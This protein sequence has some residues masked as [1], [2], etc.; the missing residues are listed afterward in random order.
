[1]GFYLN[2]DGS[3]F[4]EA[5]L[6][7]IYVD[8]TELIAVTNSVLRTK[9]KY[10]CVSRP[11]RFG[12]TMTLEMLEAYY[13]KGIN[14]AELFKHTKIYKNHDFAKYANKYNVLHLNMAN[15]ANKSVDDMIA[16]LNHELLNDFRE[17]YPE[18]KLYPDDSI[19]KLIAKIYKLSKMYFIVIID[20]W[21]IIFRKSGIQNNENAQE[22][23]LDFLREWLKDN[24]YIALVY[25]TGILPIKKYGEHSAL[26]MFTQYSMED[27]QELTEF[28]GFTT[29]DVKKLC[30]KYHRSYDTCKMWYDGYRLGYYVNDE[31]GIDNPVKYDIYN[32]LAV[33]SAMRT[34]SFVNY[35]SKT[36]NYE[37]L[38]KY[39]MINADNLK[40]IIIE[41]I[42]GNRHKVDTSSFQNDMYTF[43]SANDILTLLIHLGYLAYD[44][45]TQEVFIPNK[46]IQAEFITSIKNSDGWK[47]VTD[48]IQK[49]DELLNAIWCKNSEIVGKLMEEAHLE[50]SHLQYNDENALSYT[51][52]LALYSA[53]KYY[54]IIR[55]MPA[56]KGFAD[57]IFIPNKNNLDKPAL[58]VE[59][60]W[61]K[62]V[63]TAIDQI[64]NKQ[65]T[66]ELINFAGN[67]ILVGITYNKDVDKEKRTH[68]CIIEKINY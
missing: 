12:K 43:H 5:L 58:V 16:N 9:N 50:T 68:S 25:M 62:T 49:S 55:E 23:Y 30:A 40:D 32:P 63:R 21:D 34:G 47:N 11:R 38:Q 7:E 56:G 28:T 1:M 14:A 19:A 6:S 15:F 29:E 60:K 8:K 22:R 31:N 64:K 26:N 2:L 20:E 36:E 3:A 27:Q 67:I 59:L 52:S 46:E 18:A 4:E 53:R 35:W 10:M 44:F 33:V 17:E 65:Y 37:A 66:K 13:T 54:T 61:D 45:E 51:I 48:A 39:I 41:L 57:L 24:R 42:A